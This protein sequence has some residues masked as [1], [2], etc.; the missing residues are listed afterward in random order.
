MA[1]YYH[2]VMCHAE[3]K[4]VHYFQCQDDSKGLYNQNRT[5][6]YYVF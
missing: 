2:K 3:K 6:F 4:K 1:V 5:I